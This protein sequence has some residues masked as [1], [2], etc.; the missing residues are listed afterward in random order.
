M[1]SPSRTL[2]F[3]IDGVNEPNP[4][5]GLTTGG[6]VRVRSIT[7]PMDGGTRGE[8]VFEDWVE[9][10]TIVFTLKVNQEFPIS[11]RG[12]RYPQDIGRVISRET[13][14]MVE[15]LDYKTWD[16]ESL[17]RGSRQCARLGYCVHFKRSGGE[18]KCPRVLEMPAGKVI[19]AESVWVLR[20]DGPPCREEE[21]EETR[22][23]EADFRGETDRKLK[24]LRKA[25]E[26]FAPSILPTPIAPPPL[27]DPAS[28]GK[29]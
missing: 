18:Y 28:L 24:A 5:T 10:D 22:V 29:P 25:R 19:D 7:S 11:I 12:K 16:S 9:G 17:K 14:K 27:A 20:E 2:R 26:K 8:Q 4:V 23:K 6:A 3:K 15:P 1:P 21:L 13:K